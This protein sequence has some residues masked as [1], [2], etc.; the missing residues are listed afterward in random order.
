MPIYSTTTLITTDVINGIQLYPSGTAYLPTSSNAATAAEFEI[1]IPPTLNGNLISNTEPNPYI[2]IPVISSSALN[3]GEDAQIIIRFFTSSHFSDF[4]QQRF[5]PNGGGFNVLSVS[6]SLYYTGSIYGNYRDTLVDPST[7][8]SAFSISIRNRIHDLITGSA[9]YRNGF[10]SAS[11]QGDYTSSIHFEGSRGVLNPIIA[12]TGSLSSSES[13]S[14]NVKVEGTGSHNFTP[15]SRILSPSSSSLQI[16]FDPEDGKSIS[17]NTGTSSLGYSESGRTNDTI[18]YFSG[19]GKVGLNT[20]DPQSDFDILVNEAQFQKPGTRKGL[21][22]NQDG[23]IESFDKDP[24]TASTGSEFLLRFSRGTAITKAST[25]AIGLGPFADDAAAQAFFNGLKPAEQN[26]ILEKIERIGFIDPPQIGDTLGSIRWVAE[27]GSTSGYNDRS[28]GETA[29]IKAVV[30]DGAPDGIAADLIFSVAGKTGAAEQKFLLDAGNVHQLTG[31][32]NINGGLT[33]TSTATFTQNVNFNGNIVG[34]VFT[35]IENIS[36][37]SGFGN[38]SMGNNGN[39]V[40]QLIGDTFIKRVSDDG[41][42]L[43]FQTSGVTK[44]KISHEGNITASGNISASGYVYGRQLEQNDMSVST[45][46]PIDSYI[47]FPLGGQTRNDSTSINDSNIQKLTIVPGRPR[48]AVIRSIDPGNGLGNTKFTCSYHAANEGTGSISLIAAK[49]A[50][51]TGTN[52][53][54]VTFDFTNGVDEGSWDD[55]PA[56]ARVYMSIKVPNTAFLS[57]IDV[58]GATSLWEWDYGA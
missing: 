13:F 6:S 30:S 35:N 44:L 28:T 9:L 12:Y 23:N 31:S 48:K 16:K 10:I 26:S 54:A 8:G 2:I 21:K 40:H 25:E 58:L 24:A 19:S 1:I 4:N 11:K 46:T 49:Y 52:H 53:E 56:G 33:A 47:Y 38:V 5:T 45:I 42:D 55:V 29:V 51:S 7:S 34:D 3:T 22:I 50:S 57:E 36:S 15:S 37:I 32:L 39:E 17:F 41:G 20:N 43:L 27:S 14:V 18:L